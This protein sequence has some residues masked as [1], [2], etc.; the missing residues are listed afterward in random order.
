VIVDEAGVAGVDAF[1]DELTRRPLANARTPVIL[2][3]EKPTLAQVRRRTTQVQAILSK[4]VNKDALLR[5]VFHLL[6]RAP[7]GVPDAPAPAEMIWRA[8]E[9]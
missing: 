1:L 6:N 8:A 5:R 3:L 7:P 9:A 2:L 4:P